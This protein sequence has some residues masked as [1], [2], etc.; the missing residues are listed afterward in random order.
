[1]FDRHRLI[2]FH[3]E[4]GLFVQLWPNL[5]FSLSFFFPLLEQKIMLNRGVKPDSGKAQKICTENTILKNKF[6]K[7]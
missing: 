6:T 1:M 4:F 2:L 3:F 5:L 7:Y